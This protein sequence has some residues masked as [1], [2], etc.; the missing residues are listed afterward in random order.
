MRCPV[1]D[2]ADAI[3]TILSDPLVA[4]HL[5][6]IPNPYTLADAVFFLEHIVPNEWVWAI[7]LPGSAKLIGV[8][9]LMPQEC[10]D[11]AELGYW[12]SPSFWNQGLITEAARLVVTYG[13]EVLGLAAVTSGCFQDN[14]ASA[15]VLAK[16]GFNETR[17]A[18]RPGALGHNDVESIEV[19]LYARNEVKRQ[20][21]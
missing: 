21:P 1:P 2:D 20:C 14:K 5:S 6:L 15:R 10:H 12:L 4:R 18:K 19:T 16:L 9:S 13:F 17:R 8:V 7:N 11:V 3:V